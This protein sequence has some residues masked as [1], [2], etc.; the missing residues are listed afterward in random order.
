[1]YFLLAPY[2]RKL[3]RL[4]RRIDNIG[5][6][7]NDADCPVINFRIYGYAAGFSNPQQQPHEF[8]EQPHEFDQARSRPLPDPRARSR[9]SPRLL[10]SYCPKEQTLLSPRGIDTGEA[11]D[12]FPNYNRQHQE[13]K[14]SNINT[15][16]HSR[17]EFAT[18]QKMQAVDQLSGNVAHGVGQ[19]LA[20]ERQQMERPRILNINDVL[21]ELSYLLRRLIGENIELKVVHGHDLALA[22]VDQGQLEQ[23][24]INLTVNARDAMPDGGTLTFRTAN[25]TQGGAVRR[26]DEIMPQGEYVLIEVRDTGVGIP[27]E[28]LARIFE[29]F[30]STKEV[31]SD[32]GAG[33]PTV[34]GIVKQTGGFIF[35]DS[36]PGGGAVFQIYLPLA[37]R[38]SLV[39]R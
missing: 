35:V 36:T 16:K 25:I 12:R 22:K 24:I 15:R 39:L 34:Y 7:S 28:N 38:V 3:R 1:M 13:H 17:T 4:E 37:A 32:T 21:V 33:L 19:H 6:Q 9:T 5:N 31:G 27:K 8:H 30:F 14:N 29:P 11:E 23:V 26:G 18:V 10:L 2:V 20:F